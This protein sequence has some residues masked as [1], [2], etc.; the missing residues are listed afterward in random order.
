MIRMPFRLAR[1][2]MRLVR[3]L[4]GPRRTGGLLVA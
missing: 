2:F 1:D 4:R 3:M